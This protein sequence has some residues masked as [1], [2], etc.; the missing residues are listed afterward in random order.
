MGYLE[1]DNLGYLK[2][3]GMKI[4]NVDDYSPSMVTINGERYYYKDSTIG[5][6]KELIIDELAKDFDIECANYDLASFS[7]RCGLISKDLNSGNQEF[8]PMY[9][10]LSKFY[11]TTDYRTI[12]YYNNIDEISIMLESKFDN[13]T[14]QKLMDQLDS[15]YI[16]DILTGNSD[17]NSTN[18]GLLYRNGSVDLVILDNEFGMD[19]DVLYSEKYQ[20]KRSRNRDSILDVSCEKIKRGLELISDEHIEDVFDRVEEKIH[21]T[22]NE[23]I[24]SKTRTFFRT[25]RFVISKKLPQSY[26]KQL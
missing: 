23:G 22:I 3:D 4:E 18:Y 26:V 13:E 20:L 5:A 25:S 9:E 8:I 12:K 11:H 17:R 2:L 24:K 14:Y 15:I 7:Y 16:F 1:R 6:F 10:E 21:T 19:T